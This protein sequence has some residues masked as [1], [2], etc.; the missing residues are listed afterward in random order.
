[1]CHSVVGLQANSKLSVAVLIVHI[2]LSMTARQCDRE[3]LR[4]AVHCYRLGFKI[5]NFYI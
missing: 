5:K 4:I 3:M 2:L 1:M